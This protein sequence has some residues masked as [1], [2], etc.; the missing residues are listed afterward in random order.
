MTLQEATRR[1]LSDRCIFKI[2]RLDTHGRPVRWWR[3]WAKRSIYFRIEFS[4]SE[5]K[6]IY[7]T[8]EERLAH[9][10]DH[11]ELTKYSML[12]SGEL[13]D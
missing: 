1:V 8:T 5:K 9:E 10:V 7:F 6:F 2:E 11:G 13:Y 3:L 12:W 4:Y